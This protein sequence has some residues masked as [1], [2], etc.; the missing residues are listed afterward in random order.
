MRKEWET[1]N[2]QRELTLRDWKEME[3]KNMRMGGLCYEGSGK[4]GRRME[5]AEGDG[6][7]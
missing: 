4:R 1:K 2:W 7:G 5:K 3:A 6:D